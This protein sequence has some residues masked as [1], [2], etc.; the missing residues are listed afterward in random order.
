[1]ERCYQCMQ[2]IENTNEKCSKCG[3]EHKGIINEIHL[4]PGDILQDRYTVGNSIG[5][6]GF[7]I[8]YIGYDQKLDVRVAIKEYF[9]ISVSIRDASKNTVRSITNDRESFFQYG[10]EKFIEEAKVLAKFNGQ[11]GIVS[12]IDYFKANGTAYI[13]MEYLDGVSLEKY[14]E[15]KGGKLDVR[16][17][18]NVIIPVLDGLIALHQEGIIHRDISPDNIFIT[19]AGKVKIIDLG[20]ARYAFNE[21]SSDMTVILKRG[22]APAEQYSRQGNQGAWSDVYAVGATWYKLITGQEMVEAMSR[23]IGENYKKPSSLG[24]NIKPELESVMDKSLS[25]HPDGRYQDIS[26]FKN[27][28]INAFNG[29]APS[30]NKTEIIQDIGSALNQNPVYYKKKKRLKV[31]L[32]LAI[33]SFLMTL[34]LVFFG[35]NYLSDVL[36]NEKTSVEASEDEEPKDEL[37]YDDT[38]QSS[39]SDE[40]LEV[41]ESDDGEIEL[42]TLNFPEHKVELEYGES[43]Q[44]TVTSNLDDLNGVVLI[45][46][47]E[48]PEIASV[49]DDGEVVGLSAGDTVI[50][51]SSESNDITTECQVT[52]GSPPV[53]EEIILN[54]TELQLTENDLYTL[55]ATI[56]PS[57][58]INDT[59]MWHSNNESVV[60]I[61]ENGNL[62]AIGIGQAT[63]KAI[64]DDGRVTAEC[65]VVVD[66]FSYLQNLNFEET[67]RRNKNSSNVIELTPQYIYFN[68]NGSLIRSTYDG[69]SYIELTDMIHENSGIAIYDEMIYFYGIKEGST[70]LYRIRTDGSEQSEEIFKVNNLGN[71]LGFEGCHPDDAI[72]EDSVWTPIVYRNMIYIRFSVTYSNNWDDHMRWAII[73]YDPEN[74]TYSLEDSHRY[75]YNNS[76]VW[77]YYTEVWFGNGYLYYSDTYHNGLFEKPING[78]SVLISNA[79]ADFVLTDETH[80]YYIDMDS[81]SLNKMTTEGT[82]D[83][84]LIDNVSYYT[85]TD[86][87]KI[88]Y[89]TN[90]RIYSV[91]KNFENNPVLIAEGFERFIYAGD[92]LFYFT[93]SSELRRVDIETGE[94][95]SIH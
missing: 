40:S 6:G 47:S 69:D 10:L 2:T 77:E 70:Y 33:I 42:E 37:S 74:N 49:N 62:E 32:P 53:V 71:I 82:M 1:M 60:V 36:G 22:Y 90:N 61:N 26:S 5:Q 12:V 94:D 4:I 19:K 41:A 75:E 20:A 14:L 48:N 43:R 79:A 17:S 34:T 8:T 25:Y 56:Q 51:V 35:W 39:N 89:S 63:V 95:I 16:E 92:Y 30:E 72:Y 84:V 65:N 9:P 44:L 45:W 13:V 28:L 85:L 23:S 46:Q 15:S 86:F 66:R 81:N 11:A 7:G 83:T 76:N 78:E 80:I 29:I 50:T 67:N 21:K 68:H 18:I 73:C 58:A 55:T 27:E 87:D 59:I 3:Y 38:D 52:I 24:V 64:S 91:D 88:I 57:D 93:S 54:T 31:I